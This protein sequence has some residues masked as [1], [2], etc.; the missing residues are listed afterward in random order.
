MNEQEITPTMIRDYRSNFRKAKDELLKQENRM[1]LRGI[2]IGT[3]IVLAMMLGNLF[4]GALIN[5]T[6]QTGN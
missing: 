2:I 6:L 4:I 1:L 5:T 3:L